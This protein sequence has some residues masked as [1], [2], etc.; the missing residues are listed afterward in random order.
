MKTIILRE[1]NIIEDMHDAVEY[2]AERYN[3]R[4]QEINDVEHL[5]EFIDYRKVRN[6][7]YKALKLMKRNV[8]ALSN[9]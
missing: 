1:E 8:E 5:A 6:H 2:I 4:V 3:Q 7:L 9:H